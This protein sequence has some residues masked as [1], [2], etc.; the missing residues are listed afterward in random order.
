MTDMER[1]DSLETAELLFNALQTQRDALATE[2]KGT[3]ELTAALKKALPD[4]RDK[5]TLQ[6]ELVAD[7]AELIEKQAELIKLLRRKN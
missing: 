4:I 7:Q 1:D 6:A 5:L 3:D 2:R